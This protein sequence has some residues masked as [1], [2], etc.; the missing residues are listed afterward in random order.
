MK[1]FVMIRGILYEKVTTI[2][3][4]YALDTR[5]AKYTKQVLEME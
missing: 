5:E 2:R 1:I 4:L 3:N